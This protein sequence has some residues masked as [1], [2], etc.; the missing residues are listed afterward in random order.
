MFHGNLRGEIDQSMTG[1]ADVHIVGIGASAGGLES[2]ERFFSS[3]PRHSGLAFVVIQHLSPDFK[4]LM[5]ELLARHTEIPIHR[6]EDGMPVAADNIYLLPPK[7]EMIISGGRLHL[8]DKDPKQ[9]LTLPIDH[10]LRSLA[11]DCGT[12]A[13]AVILS[14][15]GSDGS[16]G[17]QEV[18]K[19]GGYVFCEDVQSAKFDGM[20]LSAQET[21]VVDEVLYADRMADALLNRLRA[22]EDRIERNNQLSQEPAVGVQAV[23][24]LLRESY[25]IDFSHYK[26]A[27]VSRRIERRLALVG[28]THLDDYVDRLRS[29]AGE[30]NALYKDLLIGVTKFFRDAEPFDRLEREIIPE[31]LQRVPRDEEIRVW[32]AGCAT[33]EE[34]YSIAI[35]L[36][37]ALEKAERPINVK[38]LATDVHKASLDQASLGI[39]DDDQLAEVSRERLARYF[40]KRQD[41]YKVS[42]DLRQ[43]IIFAHHNVLKDS[44]FTNLDL[45]SCRNLLIY[46]QPQ[47]QKKAISLFHFGLKTGS[48]LMLG[49]S[50]APGE[51]AD[52]FA[53]V[54]EHCKLYRKRRDIRLP[55]DIRLP[56]SRGTHG[57]RIAA[58]PA[59]SA[60]DGLLSTYDKL[61]DKFMPPSLLVNGSRELIESFGGAERLLRFKG[62]RP[63]RNLLDLLDTDA[64][65]SIAGALNRVIKQ[66]QSLTFTGVKL[67]T[68]DEEQTFRLNIDPLDAAR[69]EERRYLIWLEPLDERH[70][71]ETSSQTEVDADEM[72]RNQV[73]HLEDELRYTKENLQ[74][75]I[76]ELETSN[77]EMQAT[78][79]ELVASNEELQSTNEELH[80]VNEE[81]YTVN[82]EHQKK[83]RELAELNQDMEHLLR[84]T[85]V[86]IIFLDR[87]L[88]IRKF[89]PQVAK[90][91][92]L[93]EQDVGRRITTFS[94]RI[95][96]NDLV[97]DLEAVLE[98]GRPRETEVRDLDGS[99]HFLRILPYRV[100]DEIEGVVLSL[101]DISV[102]EQARGRISQ[103]SAIVESS[104]DAIISKDLEGTIQSWNGGAQRLYG[105]TAAEAIGCNISMIV[106]PEDRPQ[107]KT[108]LKQLRKGKR[109]E[110][111]EAERITKDGRRVQV[112]LTISP[113]TDPYSGETVGASAIAR[114]ITALKSTRHKLQDREIRT[115][116][117]VESALDAIISMNERGEITE[118]NPQAVAIFGYTAKEALG[119]SLAELIIPASQHAAHQQGMQQFFESGEGPVIGQRLELEAVNKAGVNFPV[120]LTVVVNQFDEGIEFTG[121]VRDI[122]KRR[123]AERQVKQE[124]ERRDR[125][126][127]ML[128]HELRN[129]MGAVLNALRL[130]DLDDTEDSTR[131][132]P[133]AVVKRQTEH[134]ARLLD[135]LLDVSRIT[136]NKIS[137]QREVVDLDQTVEEVVQTIE[138][139]IDA[140]DQRLSIEISGAPLRVWGDP[141]RLRQV[142][143]NL[144]SN[145]CKYTPENGSIELEMS[146]EEEQVVIRVRDTGE[147]MSSE[148]LEH[149]FQVFVQS[150]GTL[151]R[152]RGGMG[153]GLAISKSIVLA[154]QGT[155]EAH[156]DGPGLGSEFTVRLPLTQREPQ[157]AS[158][159]A[160]AIDFS[161]C[162]ILLAEDNIDARQMLAK[163]LR[164]RGFDVVEAG[165]GADAVH[166]FKV[167]HP[168]VAV[169][170]IGLPQLD[171]YEVARAIRNEPQGDQVLLLALTGYG[172]R[173]DRQA[174][175]EAGFDAHLVKPLNPDEL[176]ALVS[177]KSE[178]KH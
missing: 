96:H 143:L 1:N 147:G 40:I 88:C 54:D 20:P 115:R 26:P 65:T 60:S 50:E 53:T 174:S 32:V 106:P 85:D 91:F 73:T 116:K 27:T 2:L 105:Y 108:W 169:V 72:S 74:A 154:H 131:S 51:L 5:D 92:D 41:D 23:F 100:S 48:V 64:K 30:L 126:L 62:R 158:A 164:G 150:D 79:Q 111:V 66:G 57:L 19:A 177:A 69:S 43:L 110:P 117:I 114:D 93:L 87:N 52:E 137:Y 135:D 124:V 33:G 10:F 142:Q 80:S 104:Q 176:I 6:A 168:D 78:N 63:S 163:I 171:G 156:S 95:R 58:T 138:H 81:L 141:A 42:Q 15:T 165:N 128:S 167:R 76:E 11:H 113:I 134:M 22:P 157:K 16:R 121:F 123:R 21:G 151:H 84:S 90:T 122:S 148:L 127:A 89:T 25:D 31:I 153:L 36:H 9:A 139:L 49:S 4:S 83:I 39:F 130:A 34:P 99:C 82:A 3:M 140:K 98:D 70:P 94:H 172:R 35:L 17:I 7:K 178:S 14:G 125:F 44:P 67:K 119:S 112:S 46:F 132:E 162:R 175:I 155:I 170:D 107:V 146:R 77:E 29:D 144:L 166:E 68:G 102:L 28:D 45:I 18:H 159:E 13:M 47:A 12:R 97:K 109:V 61:L 129:P 160:P 118:W 149:V 133:L 86:G 59:V 71:F 55:A 38:I 75:T 161:G 173:D 101:I 145:A 136:Q 37:E 120:E 8:A 56:L 24:D 103:L 152:S